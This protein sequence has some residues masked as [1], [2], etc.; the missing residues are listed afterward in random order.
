MKTLKIINLLGKKYILSFYN[1]KIIDLFINFLNI[2]FYLFLFKINKIYEI[3]KITKFQINFFFKNII[4][5]LLNLIFLRLDILSIENHKELKTTFWSL[6]KKLKITTLVDVGSH[7]SNTLIEF[8][9]NKVEL[10]YYIGF[11]P[12]KESIQKAK[13]NIESI[14]FK[15]FNYEINNFAISSIESD[16][17]FNVSK[18]YQ[19]SSLLEIKK[20]HVDAASSSEVFQKIKVKTQRLEHFKDKFLLK[21]NIFLKIDTQGSEM[22]VLNSL[23]SNISAVS[24]IQLE[25]SYIELYKKSSNWLDVLLFME[26]NHFKVIDVKRVFFDEKKY[27]LLQS[28]FIF[29][30]TKLHGDYI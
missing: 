28:D 21:G 22:D 12:I 30:N 6:L 18:N 2:F 20:R 11:E 13:E 5:F 26:N 14:N 4:I 27:Q 17:I 23:G 15:D 16:K 25:I 8:F 19:S 1:Y 9:Q 10:K 29:I 3:E 7:H 24:L